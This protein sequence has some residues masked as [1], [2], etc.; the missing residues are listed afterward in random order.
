MFGL[1][2]KQKFEILDVQTVEDMQKYLQLLDDKFIQQQNEIIQNIESF[3]DM[4]K[5]FENNFNKK[6]E[7]SDSLLSR[8]EST[9]EN[10]SEIKAIETQ[11]VNI[12]ENT[13]SLT[14]LEADIR[15]LL[16]DEI[17][18]IKEY[19]I[20]QYKKLNRHESGYDK[21]ILGRFYRDIFK[22]LDFIK[23]EQQSNKNE[24]VEEIE[25]DL[26]ILL[27]N[28]NV[29]RLDIYEGDKY[30]SENLDA[31]VQVEYLDTEVEDD[32][33]KII[34]IKKDGYVLK[35]GSYKIPQRDAKIIVCKFKNM[36]KN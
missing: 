9:I 8:V 35:N 14:T 10:V 32:D 16:I 3:K 27:E 36:E 31:Y 30:D 12:T 4:V 18:P 28:S 24:V 19:A 25:D 1:D 11:L 21:K 13:K 15:Q 2:K 7:K 29:Y 5:A 6:V 20:N 34:K 33:N 22:I 17:T 23:K 26:I